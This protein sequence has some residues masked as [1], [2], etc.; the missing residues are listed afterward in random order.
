MTW[1]TSLTT[2]RERFLRRLDVQEGY[3]T[4]ALYDAI[5]A[6]PGLIDGEEPGRWTTDLSLLR[7]AVE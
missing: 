5:A 3:G 7:V 2:D 1:I 4:T 6:S